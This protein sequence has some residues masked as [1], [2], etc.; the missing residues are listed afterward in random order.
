VP[1][2]RAS[3]VPFIVSRVVVL[4]A[5][6]TARLCVSSFKLGAA[7][8]GPSRSGLL[9]WDAHCTRGSPPTATWARKRSSALFPIAAGAGE[10]VPCVPGMS[11]GLSVIVVAN[12]ACLAA[13]V[14]L[15]RL[16]MFELGDEAC[17]RR[18][19]GF[20]LWRRRPSS[21]RWATGVV[22]PT[23][24]DGGLLGPATTPLRLAVCAGFAAGLC[25][26]VGMLLVIPAAIEVFENWRLLEIRER[27]VGAC[28]VLAAPLGA[29]PTS[30]GP[31]RLWELPA[32]AA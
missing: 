10:V 20:L 1:G 23:D 4:V 27:I 17:A 6:F 24:L 14:V 15:H 29:A 13:L 25:R 11:S 9:S 5:L 31:R 26:P 18:A 3:V 16:V 12:V 28:A 21:S 32:A 30:S 19:C 7:A 2:L 8:R 22:V